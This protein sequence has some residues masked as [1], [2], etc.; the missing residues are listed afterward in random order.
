M[1]NWTIRPFSNRRRRRR[2]SRAW[3]CPRQHNKENIMRHG[4]PRAACH[5]CM[6]ESALHLRN[7]HIMNGQCN[8]IP[9]GR[10]NGAPVKA[11]LGRHRCV[12]LRCNN[13]RH[14]A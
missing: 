11:S 12:T 6:T 14:P 4:T 3:K 5:G 10:F 1:L 13:R 7:P 2:E 8:Q 9:P